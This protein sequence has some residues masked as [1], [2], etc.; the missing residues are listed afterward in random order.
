M[1]RFMPLR[2]P[3]KIPMD[4]RLMSKSATERPVWETVQPIPVFLSHPN[5]LTKYP[6]LVDSRR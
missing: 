1:P 3:A 6:F 4:G 5:S 2:T